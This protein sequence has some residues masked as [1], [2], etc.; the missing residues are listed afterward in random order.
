MF[1][2]FVLILLLIC[3]L[4]FFLPSFFLSLFFL[5][6][7]PSFF[8]SI[9]FSSFFPS[10]L[11]YSLRSFIQSVFLPSFLPFPLFSTFLLSVS[12]LYL[13]SDLF[14]LLSINPLLPVISTF[15]KIPSVRHW[16]KAAGQLKKLKVV[17]RN[18]PIK[19]S[20][21]Y[22]YTHNELLKSFH[23]YIQQF[24]FKLSEAYC[25]IFPFPSIFRFLYDSICK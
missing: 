15:S 2:F 25:I 21:S 16:N 6:F 13:F 5:S 19:L 8:L 7:S 9:C 18:S 24:S 23:S 3:L 4:S 20:L 1:R 14:T 17:W 11:S 12:V 22:R 10:F